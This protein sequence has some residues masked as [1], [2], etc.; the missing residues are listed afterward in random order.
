MRLLPFIRSVSLLILLWVSACTQQVKPLEKKVTRAT[1][2]ASS[3]PLDS[4]KFLETLIDSAERL[5]YKGLYYHAIACLNTP[6]QWT[7]EEK[8][9]FLHSFAK[10]HCLLADINDKRIHTDLLL[11]NA[12]DFRYYYNKI[13]SDEPEYEALYY[14]YLSRYYN[15]QMMVD[16]GLEY[17]KKS[18]ALF[19]QSKNK[20]PLI[21]VFRIYA[22]HLFSLR[23]SSATFQQKEA[24]KDTLLAWVE[25][26]YPVEHIEKS[27]QIVSSHLF[28]LDSIANYAEGNCKHPQTPCFHE[29]VAPLEKVIK[30]ETEKINALIGERNPYTARN[31]QLIGLLSFYMHETQKAKKLY[32]TAIATLLL[33]DSLHFG[34]LTP[35]NAL[36]TSS[37]L[38]KAKCLD[39]EYYK[40]GAL[41]LLL[42]KEQILQQ[43]TLVW[44]HY[45]EEILGPTT[46]FNRNKYTQNPYSELQQTYVQLY[47]HTGA[48]QYKTKIYHCGELAGQYSLLYVLAQNQRKQTYKSREPYYIAFE[49]YY[50]QK[51]QT[52]ADTLPLPKLEIPF[53]F[54]YQRDLNQVKQRLNENEVLVVYNKITLESTD[55]LLAQ[56]IE[57][58]KDSVFELPLDT[59]KQE[60]WLNRLSNTGRGL[61]LQPVDSFKQIGEDLYAKLFKPIHSYLSPSIRNLKIIRNP[62]LENLILPIEV[63]LT[64]NKKDVGYKNLP[65]LGKEYAINYPLSFQLQEPLQKTKPKNIVIFIASDSALGAFH[66]AST[67][68]QKIKKQYKTTLITGRLASKKNV[69]AALQK[70]SLVVIISH[71]KGSVT[72]KEQGLYLSDGFLGIEEINTLK[73]NSPLLILAG[74]ST[75]V[76][77]RSPEGNINLARAFTLGGTKSV[78]ITDW[79]VDEKPTLLILEKFFE[80][81]QANKGSAYALQ[82]AKTELLANSSNQLSNPHYWASFVLVGPNQSF[83]LYQNNDEAIGLILAS[84]FTIVITALFLFGKIRVG[85]PKKED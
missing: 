38:W 25:Y 44:Q 68:A 52:F 73:S 64:N 62:V 14:A 20:K 82:E 29:L 4:L 13:A 7:Q 12:Q 61:F 18:V 21:P 58:Y 67:F 32:D 16:K 72:E 47:K 8:D 71:G 77:F 39:K 56:V 2:S 53:D 17:S 1:V 37:L 76:G 65:Y 30:R 63:L 81:L 5:Q 33:P 80:K 11:K 35:Y 45:I 84:I 51:P 75:G 42:E 31:N 43:M 15:L 49:N 70:N 22:N 27:L 74:C 3:T 19:K 79:D 85:A 23:N 50:S 10:I 46:S 26:E 48:E 59:R 54:Y 41:T 40:T 55:L 34:L 36:L 83:S 78:M 69:K 24:Y 57:K 28:V 66:Y 6:L 60:E 9:C